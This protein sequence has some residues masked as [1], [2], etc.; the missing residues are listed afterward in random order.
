[1]HLRGQAEAF[2]RMDDS[3]SGEDT[4]MGEAPSEST[5]KVDGA[6]F[7]VAID[8][9]TTFSSV[10][11][12]AT[13]DRDRKMMRYSS[14][15]NCIGNFQNDPS[16]SPGDRKEVPT[17]SWYR[18]KP[19]EK[20]AEVLSDCNNQPGSLSE[21]VDVGETEGLGG[22]EFEIPSDDSDDEAGQIDDD[23]YLWG[24]SVQQNLR[25]PIHD[26]DRDL[27]IARSKLLL[28]GSAA[29]PETRTKLNASMKIL[30]RK[31]YIKKDV[32]IITDFLAH[33]LQHT[34]ENLLRYHSFEESMPLEF[35]VCVPATWTPAA[36]RIM[37]NAMAQA[38]KRAVMGELS[39]ECIQNMFIVS[40][41]EAAAACVLTGST[42]IQVNP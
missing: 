16:G 30:R 12:R 20:N 39:N 25:N 8:F 40:E 33:L 28:G 32:D 37:Q 22:T 21:Q 9:G 3:E 13:D 26:F 38:V 17:E 35:V 23:K 42:D 6:C 7:I 34:K 24:Y 14:D 1:M 29:T 4:D 10:A 27:R 31:G 36:C 11:L 2:T 15:I 5:D 18:G 19:Y 41:A